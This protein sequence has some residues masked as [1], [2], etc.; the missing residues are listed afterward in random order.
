[1]FRQ[2]T[3]CEKSIM[4]G[5]KESEA[6]AW[7]QAA[8]SRVSEAPSKS[9]PED[10]GSSTPP[11]EHARRFINDEGVRSAGSDE[12]TEFLKSK[13]FDEKTIQELLAE[14]SRTTS[15]TSEADADRSA[16]D[17][18]ERE[19]PSTTSSNDAPP[20]VTYPEFLTKPRRRPPLLT[21]SRLLNILSASGS[22]MTLA[23][24]VAQYLISP[25]IATR[26][27]RQSEYYNHVDAKLA[28]LNS[29]LAGVVS[30]VPPPRTR[31]S[32]HTPKSKADGDPSADADADDASSAGDP[33]ELFHRDIGT[34]TS[35][36][37]ASTSQTAPST[38]SAAP[39]S[40]T[41]RQE[42]ALSSVMT[43]MR[44]LRETCDNRGAGLASLI[45][46]VQESQEEFEK[47]PY[48]GSDSGPRRTV[49][50]ELLSLYGQGAAGGSH[51]PDDEFKKTRDAIRSLKG[52][53]LST[54]SFPGL[55]AR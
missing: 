46:A 15:Q 40:H 36:E 28:E 9:Q 42:R 23:Y 8:E 11:R 34:Q 41:A 18:V 21:P 10:T 37:P 49:S 26:D 54:R 24:G 1:M 7:Q 6:P 20:I 5:P 27:E 48:S 50:S 3:D 55:M 2:P 38:A 25:M 52:M 17:T 19:T 32:S 39:I 12:K 31:G 35:P 51:E 53:L 22:L 30:V 14:S 29:R 45:D 43:S 47:G 33:T 4:S 13:G 16:G 44:S